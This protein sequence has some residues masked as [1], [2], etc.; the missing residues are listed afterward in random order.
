MRVT[1]TRRGI[2]AGFYFPFLLLLIMLLMFTASCSMGRGRVSFPEKLK[3][4]EPPDYNGFIEKQI[5]SE[6]QSWKGIPHKDGG[7][8]R[9]GLDCSAFVKVMYQKLFNIELPRSTKEQILVGSPVA[10]KDLRAGDLVFFK[11]SH[12]PRHVGIYLSHNEFVH[13]SKDRGV[14][15][16]AIS[17]TY[18]ERYYWTGR[19]V[20]PHTEAKPY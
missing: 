18:W 16:S 1:H 14:I 7:E 13:V 17:S 19:R 2:P 20:L 15:I 4:I 8:N 12:A 5:L 3:P 6:Y 10:R 11:P 9:N